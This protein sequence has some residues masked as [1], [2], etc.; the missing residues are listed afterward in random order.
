LDTVILAGGLSTRM[1]RKYAATN[2]YGREP[3]K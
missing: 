1:V 2:I 3:R